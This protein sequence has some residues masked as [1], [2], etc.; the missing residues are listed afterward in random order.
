MREFYLKNIMIV[1]KSEKNILPFG[2][3][4]KKLLKQ[5]I[6]AKTYLDTDEIPL[7]SEALYITD[8]DEMLQKLQW[9]GM[10]V[11]GF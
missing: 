9:Q 2:E 10:W 3:L 11:L 7:L 6:L 5:G 8:C 4:I 1:L